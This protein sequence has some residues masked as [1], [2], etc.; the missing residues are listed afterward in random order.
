M[1]AP[2]KRLAEATRVKPGSKVELAKDFDPG[3][4]D[5]HLQKDHGAAAQ[6]DAKAALLDL[7]DRFFA[8]ADR[9]LLIILQAID[10]AGKDGTIKHVMSGLNPEGVDVYS[11]KA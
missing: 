5:K 8:Q 3:R 11:F 1:S 9:S 7:Q 6:A 4:Y 10:A 2:W